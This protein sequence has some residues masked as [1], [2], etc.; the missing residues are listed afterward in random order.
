MITIS[1]VDELV[2]V[3]M[4]ADE[5]GSEIVVVVVVV[6]VADDTRPNRRDMV[7]NHVAIGE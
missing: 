1:P 5:D 7:D 3:C 4:S 6:L 2:N